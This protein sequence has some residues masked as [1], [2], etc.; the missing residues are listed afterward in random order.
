MNVKQR[1]RDELVSII[2]RY[3]PRSAIYLF[4]S[5]ARGGHTA[6]SDIDV[7]IDA[8]GRIDYALILKILRAIDETS[9]PMTVDI[10]DLFTASEQLKKE[11]MGEGVKWT[12]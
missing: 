7:A 4:G 3:I 10:V 6:T 8:G 12:D 9:I 5:R 1:Y 11:V 2:H